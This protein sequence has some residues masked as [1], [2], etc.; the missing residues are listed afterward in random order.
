MAKVSASDFNLVQ[1]KIGGVLGTPSPS[2][3]NLGY[4]ITKVSNQV[5]QYAKVYGADLNNMITDANIASQHQTGAATTLTPVARTKLIEADDLLSVATVVNTLYNNRNV[6]GVGQLSVVTSDSY[7]NGSSWSAT[8]SYKIR[9]DWGSNSE[10]RGW[11][12]LGGFLAIGGSMSGGSGSVQ[13]SSWNSLF[14]NIG[15]V[16]LGATAA[17]QENN[18]SSGTFPNGG[19]YNIV[20]NGQIGAN[21]TIAFKQLATDLHYTSNSFQIKITPYGGTTVYTCSGIELEYLLTDTHTKTGQGPD[22][23]TA[24]LALSLN[25]YYAYNKTP[26]V[27][28][29]GSG[30]G[31]SLG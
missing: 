26:T 6:A 17:T 14:V 27:T 8:H 11:A 10:F 9:L 16:V 2:T 20:Q 28:N 23:V 24:T 18:G 29:S 5:A 13:D 22:V 21:A 30:L 3:A 4:N 7:S 25:V 31:S 1:S 19:L 15:T 12:N